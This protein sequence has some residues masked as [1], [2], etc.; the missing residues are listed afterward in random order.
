M[1]LFLNFV[2]LAFSALLPVINP[3]GSALI[4][5]GLVG[6]VHGETLHKLAWRVA[7]STVLFLLAVELLGSAFLAF[8][9]ISLPVVQ[10]A[11]G[12]VLASMG[13]KMLVSS[14]A[15]GDHFGTDPSHRPVEEQ[16]FY[17]LTFP[18]T[19]DPGCIV[20]T[21]TLS[22]HASRHALAGDFLAHVGIAVAI[23]VL[24]AAVGLCYGNAAKITQM[25]RPQT[26]AGI[27]RVVSFIVICI[28]LQIASNGV[29]EMLHSFQKAVSS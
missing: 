15:N 4:F 27:L 26:A 14:T 23:L 10:L 9:A 8:F 17:P 21:L 12:L 1:S 24:G 3:V 16:I 28:G 7:T 25:I 19:A 18:V 6:E 11:G 2:F 29:S 20:V 22:A 5:M 13:W